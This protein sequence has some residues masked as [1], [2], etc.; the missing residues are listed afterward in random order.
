M[1]KCFVS[2]GYGELV[3][4]DIPMK[5]VTADFK[6]WRSTGYGDKERW[7]PT[8]SYAKVIIV[9]D[10]VCLDKEPEREKDPEL[11]VA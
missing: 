9:S 4:I 3:E 1:A 11:E 8:G 2:V 5:N 10:A 7:Y 6:V